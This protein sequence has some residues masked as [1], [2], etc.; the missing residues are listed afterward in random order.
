LVVWGY[1][2]KV[3]ISFIYSRYVFFSQKTMFSSYLWIFIISKKNGITY[4]I[5]VNGTFYGR[6]TEGI[7]LVGWERCLWG[8]LDISLGVWGYLMKVIPETSL[9]PNLISSFSFGTQIMIPVSYVPGT[10]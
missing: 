4:K 5:Y 10:N 8:I 1:P 2:M 3:V 6:C 9:V 7:Y